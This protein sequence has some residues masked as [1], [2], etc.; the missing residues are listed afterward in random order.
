VKKIIHPAHRYSNLAAAAVWLVIL[1]VSISGCSSG[2]EAALPPITPWQGGQNNAEKIKLAD[3]EPDGNGITFSSVSMAQAGGWIDV[4]FKGPAL[5]VQSWSQ[6]KVFV[7]DE[8]TGKAYNQI[9]VAPVIGPLFGKPRGDNQPA[10]VM[11]VNSDNAVKAGS[12]LTVVLG[13]YKRE[14]VVVR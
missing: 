12:V 8:A 4:N 2:A 9:P 11:L 1:L 14:H 7:I 10:Y 5:L 3:T 13:D 6:G